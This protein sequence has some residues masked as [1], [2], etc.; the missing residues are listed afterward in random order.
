MIKHDVTDNDGA[1]EAMWYWKWGGGGGN[2]LAAEV[3]SGSSGLYIVRKLA[4]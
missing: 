4:F 3:Q 1:L 2:H